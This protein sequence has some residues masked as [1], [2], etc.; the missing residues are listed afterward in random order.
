M[1]EKD[2]KKIGKRMNKNKA[3]KWVKTYQKNHPD[4]THGWL[5][6]CDILCN[7]LD[8]EGAD[9]IW[10]FKGM[11]DDGSERL[12]LYPADKDGNILSKSQ[13]MKSLG[14]KVGNGEDD[15]AADE[16]QACPPNCP[17]PT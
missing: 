3:D 6:G 4:E 1:K 12:V 7:L 15:G 9:G 17:G 14:A 5:Y 11:A 10:F 8:E 16:G 13:K 2:V